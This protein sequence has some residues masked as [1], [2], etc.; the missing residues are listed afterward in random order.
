MTLQTVAKFPYSTS[1]ILNDQISGHAG[2]LVRGSSI[3]GIRNGSF[4]SAASNLPLFTEDGLVCDGAGVTVLPSGAKDFANWSSTN[5]TGAGTKITADADGMARVYGNDS[6]LITNG[7]YTKIT[8]WG[9]AGTATVGSIRHFSIGGDSENI[10]FSAAL[11][12]KW[13]RVIEYVGLKDNNS[14]SIQIFPHAGGT[15]GSASAGDSI[16]ARV[17]VEEVDTD[18]YGTP[19]SYVLPG[20]SRAAQTLEYTIASMNSRVATAL[21]GSF[22]ALYK[23][24]PK[25]DS[26]QIDATDRAVITCGDMVL[27]IDS[28]MLTATDGT[29]TAEAEVTYSS[30]DTIWAFC[31][32]DASESRLKIALVGD[33]TV[34]WDESS[35][36]YTG[37]MNPGANIE[38]NGNE[39]YCIIGAVAIYSGVPDSDAE[40]LAVR[41]G[42]ET[43]GGGLKK[44]KMKCSL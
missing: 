7:K 8:V 5:A 15:E 35:A 19:H 22:S 1:R 41:S 27:S 12:S 17:V 21:A 40:I 10:N 3:Y 11:T 33:S 31:E 4:V 43:R 16:H 34:T 25:F 36:A 14:L 39:E 24:I 30:G 26:D 2:S 6:A 20:D 38:I 9:K 13:Q 18:D 44:M 32:A 37:S 29:N 42:L 28:E 23:I